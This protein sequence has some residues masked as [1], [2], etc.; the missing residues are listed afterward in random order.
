MKIS[1]E[2]VK[3]TGQLYSIVWEKSKPL[4][5]Y[6]GWHFNKMQ[7]VIPE[8][9]VKGLAGIE[10]GS[11]CGYDTYIMAKNNPTV[12]IVSMDISDGVFQNKKLTCEMKNVNI[13]KGSALNIPMADNTFDFAYSFGVLHHLPEPEKGIKEVLRVIKNSAPAYLYLYEDHSE[14]RTKCLSLKLI[15]LLR[16]VTVRIPP[17]ILYF[18][19]F[20]FSPFVVMFFTFPARILRSCKCTR[21]IS[22]SIPFNFGTHLFSV[23]GDL[24]D[25][26]GAPIEHRF[27]R[28]GVIALLERNG[29]INISI[30]RMRSVAGWVAWGYKRND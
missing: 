5:P 29:F 30:S 2:A 27:S 20:F 26:F 16:Q 18:I 28:K 14:N 19:S 22:E 13:I 3:K 8:P 25:R 10:I 15:N 17:R 4:L 9:I 7:E 21:K 23:A 1:A 11:G 12:K 6:G 24:Y